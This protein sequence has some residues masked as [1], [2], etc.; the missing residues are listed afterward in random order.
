M[1]EKK[2]YVIG[3]VNG[4]EFAGH[5]T[6]LDANWT[7]DSFKA[8]SKAD[9]RTFRASGVPSYG[10]HVTNCKKMGCSPMK[11]RGWAW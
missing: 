1:S 7:F 8:I 5:M 11:R 4:V 10:E 3:T 6:E 2:I 9:Y